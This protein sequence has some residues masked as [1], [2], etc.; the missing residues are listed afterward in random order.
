M[1]NNR[2]KGRRAYFPDTTF[3]FKWKKSEEEEFEAAYAITVHKAQ[4]SEFSEVFVVIPERRGLLSRELVY[5]AMTRSTGPMT[6]FVQRTERENPLEV[7]RGRSDLLRR[8]SSLL[9]APLDARRVF[10]P[11]PGILVK[12]KVEYVIYEALRQARED[13]RLSFAYE[14]SLELPFE[15]EIVVVHPDFTVMIGDRRFFW[16]HLGMLDRVDYYSDWQKRR[17][18]YERKELGEQLVTS[19][20]LHGIHGHE[21]LRIIADMIESTVKKTPDNQFSRHHYRL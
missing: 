11:E 5:T 3:E 16:E 6:L 19:D 9:S 15:G 7:A 12:S 20:D 18:A 13:G 4:G 14:Q 8:N 17:E 21:V 10:E 2:N 1:N